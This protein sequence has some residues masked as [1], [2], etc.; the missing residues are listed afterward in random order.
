MKFPS[1]R[2]SDAWLSPL[3]SLAPAL[4]GLN[5]WLGV[6]DSS[7]SWMLMRAI[8]R[9]LKVVMVSGAAGS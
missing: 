7:S 6:S 8:V 4:P 5:S 9:V 2:G 1:Q 3:L